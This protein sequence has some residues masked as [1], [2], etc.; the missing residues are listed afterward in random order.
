MLKNLEVA[1]SEKKI[2]RSQVASILGYTRYATISDKIEGKTTF[3]FDEALKI[4]RAFF[5]EYELEFLFAK[6][7]LQIA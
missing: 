7:E 6:E 1:L 2:T 5:P 4:K 3:S